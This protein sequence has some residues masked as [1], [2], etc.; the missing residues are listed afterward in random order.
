MTANPRRLHISNSPKYRKRWRIERYRGVRRMHNVDAVRAH[1]EWLLSQG[2]TSAGICAVAGVEARTVADALNNRSQMMTV[3]LEKKIL[4]VTPADIYA[5]PYK[6][7]WVPAIGAIRRLQ[8]LVVMGWRYEDLSARL[9]FSAREIARARRWITRQRHEAMVRLYD[10]LWDKQGPGN[11]ESIDRALRKGWHRPMA[12]DD[13]T[14][15]DPNA[16]PFGTVRRA[17]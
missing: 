2:F 15:D 10:Q 16:K 17:A 14:I 6:V 12:W 11:Q 4:A 3:R 1:I 13:D 8:A 9:G 7:G 5:H